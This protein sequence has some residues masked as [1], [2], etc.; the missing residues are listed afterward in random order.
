MLSIFHQPHWPTETKS[1]AGK[2]EYELLLQ[3]PL[4]R[5]V[6]MGW[7]IRAQLIAGAILL[8][9]YFLWVSETFAANKNVSLAGTA[10]PILVFLLFLAIVSA[11]AF[12][13]LRDRRLLQTGNCVLGRVVDRVRVAGGRRRRALIVYQFA[14]GPGKPMTANGDDYT[15][16][17]STNSRVLVFFDPERLE[18]HV[19]ICSTGWRVCTEEG[20][21][22]DP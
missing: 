18:R 9:I 6:K 13:N 5:T 14:V 10:L 1:E 19:A 15:N 12:S 20:R 16:S 4:P 7:P 17:Y 22:L 21:V 2:L 3:A 8:T 11:V